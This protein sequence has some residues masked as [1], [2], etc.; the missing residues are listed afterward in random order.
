MLLKIKNLNILRN[1]LGGRVWKAYGE[2]PL[3]SG[4]AASATI[5]GMQNEGMIACAKHYV[6]NE[7]EDPRRSSST[8]IPEQA[9]WE[10]YLETIL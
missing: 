1:P 7:I 9:L 6:S 4:E 10:I 3:L 8:N 5:K 2:D